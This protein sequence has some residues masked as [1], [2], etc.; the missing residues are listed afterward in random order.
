MVV[1]SPFQIEIPK[2]SNVCHQGKEPLLPGAE[3]YS[4]LKEGTIEGTYERQDFCLTCWKQLAKE[5]SHHEVCSSWRSKIP[6]KKEASDLPKQRDARA[7]CLLKEALKSNEPDD[8]AEAFVLTLYLARRRLLYFRQDLVLEDGQPASVCEVA[9]TEE[10]LCIRKIALS[11]L[12]VEKIQQQL[13][14]KFKA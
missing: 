12:Q 7:L 9:E 6:L 8:Q 4:T 10:M 13:A 3:I 2:R 14:K 1:K 5:N 11:H